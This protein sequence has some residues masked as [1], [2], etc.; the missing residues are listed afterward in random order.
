MAKEDP[1]D[2]IKN[3]KASVE[4]KKK[5]WPIPK[6]RCCKKILT[7]EYPKDM[8]ICTRCGREYQLIIAVKL[9]NEE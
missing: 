1:Y 7:F 2:Y 6:T 9:T 8:V 4:V 5:L 3:T